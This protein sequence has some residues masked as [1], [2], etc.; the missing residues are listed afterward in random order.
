MDQ[1]KKTERI[2][3][4]QFNIFDERYSGR[5]P[6]DVEPEIDVLEAKKDPNAHA[7][8]ELMMY[9]ALANWTIGFYK[10][11]FRLPLLDDE[12]KNFLRRQIAKLPKDYDLAAFLAMV[13]RNRSKCL[14]YLKKALLP[15]DPD[16]PPLTEN[17][18]NTIVLTH[19]KNAFPG[20]YRSV[21][22]FFNDIPAEQVILNLCDVLDDFYATDNPE[23]M[24]ECLLP[25]IRNYPESVIG[26][27][28]LGYSYYIQKRYGNA[29][30]CF[31]KAELNNSWCM[32][33]DTDLLYFEGVSYYALR[34]FESAIGCYEQALALEPGMPSTLNNLGYTY[35]RI[36]KY[37]RALE[38]FRQCMDEKRDVKYAV[39][40]YARTLLAMKRIK[41]A[42]AFV[43]TAPLKVS[44]DIVRR[45]EKA[46]ERGID[47]SEESHD[48]CADDDTSLAGDESEE[49][50][51]I[52]PRNG[53]QFS[54]EK[55]LEDEL[56]A[57]IN[58]GVPVFGRQLKMYRRPGEYGRQYI[59]PIGRLD[60]LAE[61]AD[62]NL[63]IIELKKDAGYDDPYRQISDYL[64]W[65]EQNGKV[66]KNIYG[67][68][69]LNAPNAKLLQA[70]HSDKR[71]RLFNY[72]IVYEE[73]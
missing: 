64:D 14:E 24:V 23:E 5:P 37:D 18:F 28:L 12:T 33:W 66:K 20:F 30:A 17:E 7:F 32:F 53:E 65:F 8:R 57:R 40:N 38:I 22:Q 54:N 27:V 55:L 47:S 51:K 31:E 10:Y 26:N 4:E 15:L 43:K 25:F 56:E 1:N 2:D 44:P 3:D 16:V 68:I 63:Y 73:L 39:N 21:K 58:S 19:F 59:I 34:E 29:I 70:V 36:R 6:C 50:K 72:S 61:D 69:C 45:I 42:A 52:R 62:G 71:V 46:S 49:Q 41:D 11:D 48:A 35:Y 67:I 9:E 60:L 13:N